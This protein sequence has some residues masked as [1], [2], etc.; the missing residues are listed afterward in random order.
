M[1]RHI[2][3]ECCQCFSQIIMYDA[4]IFCCFC[5]ICINLIIFTL[6]IVERITRRSYK[7]SC[8]REFSVVTPLRGDVNSSRQQFLQ[9]PPVIGHPHSHRRRPLGIATNAISTR[10]AG[11]PAGGRAPA[12][13]TPSTGRPARRPGA[14][15]T[16]CTRKPAQVRR[17]HPREPCADRPP[18]SCSRPP[19]AT[20]RPRVPRANGLSPASR[21]CR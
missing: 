15:G 10:R 7:L 11:G 12:S 4:N 16:E 8:T 19:S 21:P 17:R 14:G 13:R 5:C 3:L 20:E 9:R 2:F 18:S 1:G 6:N